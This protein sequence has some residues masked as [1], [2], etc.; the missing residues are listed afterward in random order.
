MSANHDV[1]LRTRL[2]A[3]RPLPYSDVELSISD[4]VEDRCRDSKPRDVQ[5]AHLFLGTRRG[6]KVV[7]GRWGSVRGMCGRG[8]GDYCWNE[9][10]NKRNEEGTA[11][12]CYIFTAMTGVRELLCWQSE[13]VAHMLGYQFLDN[14]RRQTQRQ[15]HVHRVIAQFL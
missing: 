13:P 15:V 2:R 10:S 4:S 12:H 5:Q 11:T 8:T 7:R 14:L 3:A 9:T 6:D 1:A